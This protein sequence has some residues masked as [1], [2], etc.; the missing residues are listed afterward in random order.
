M[1]ASGYGRALCAL[2]AS[3]ALLLAGC[4]GGAGETGVA[5]PPAASGSADAFPVTIEHKYGSTTIPAEPKRIVAIGYQEH[6]FIYAL[7]SKPVAVRWWYGSETDVI[8]PWTEPKAAGESPQILKMDTIELEKIAALDPD[9]I[10]GLYSGISQDEYTKLTNIAPTITQSGKYVDYGSPW[11]ETTRTIGRALGKSAEAEK[12]V[13]DLDGRFA[14]IK[15]AHPE[16]AGKSIVVASFG[17]ENIG[18][19]ASQDPRSRFF[20]SLGF[21]VPKEFDDIAGK[22]FY[23]TLS[24]EQTNLLDRDVLVWD[25]LSFTPG[26]RA[27]VEQNALVQRMAVSKEQRSIFLEGDVEAAF[28]WN[29]VLSLPFVLDVLERELT[30][31]VRPQG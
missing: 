7:G 17:P 10:L 4:G 29:T 13:N 15:A 21:T 19:F 16:F 14:A 11:Q 8:H 24:Y 26:G 23:G 22:E 9:L 18:F 20:T 1:P 30:R 25:Q 3:A 2:V 12:L 31:V 5:P 6:D 27:T 28:G